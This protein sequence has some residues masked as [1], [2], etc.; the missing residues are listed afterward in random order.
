MISDESH[1]LGS[2]VV[3]AVVSSELSIADSAASSSSQRV[4]SCIE[5]V[6]VFGP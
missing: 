6:G 2:R 1:C 3:S 4:V 5:S